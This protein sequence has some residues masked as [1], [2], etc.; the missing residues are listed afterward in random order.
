VLQSFKQVTGCRILASDGEL[1][2]VQDVYFDDERWVVRYLVVECGGWLSQRK[3]LIAPYAVALI[4]VQAR[5]IVVSLTREQVKSSP[6]ID[7][8]KPVSR[9]QEIEYYRYYGYPAYWPHA[10]NWAWGAFPIIAAGQKT[11][12]EQERMAISAA[13][14]SGR[15]T[16]L[17]SSHEVI[18]Y[19][20]AAADDSIGH[21]E[22]FLF[23]DGS[24]EVRYL[25]ADTR[26]WWPGK[27]VLVT[28]DH[29]DQIN[30]LER[31]LSVD[32]TRE[33]LRSSPLYDPHHPPGPAENRGRGFV[34]HG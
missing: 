17:R 11:Q 29:L 7:T 9:R 23:D 18:G 6:D 24:W 10:T 28:T 2:S 20:I 22:D 15:A 31:T 34:T 3:V 8:D 4:D 1:G 16:H 26:N 30:W 33:S 27:H 19:H 32:L 14:G 25:V 21:T 12:G 5:A 13:E